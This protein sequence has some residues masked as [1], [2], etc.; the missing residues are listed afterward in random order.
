MA[1]RGISFAGN[2]GDDVSSSM[3]KALPTGSLG[4]GGPIMA[5]PETNRGAT[6]DA[7]VRPA[8]AIGDAPSGS[9]TIQFVGDI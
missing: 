3:P 4:N 2:G 7:P 6:A 9:G 8:N 1:E 5:G